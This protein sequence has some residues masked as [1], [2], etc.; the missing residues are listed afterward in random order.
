MQASPKSQ[1]INSILFYDKMKFSGFISLWAILSSFFNYKK[2][3]TT[4][5]KK[6]KICP[7]W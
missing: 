7:Y 2:L 6:N 1:I 5:R 3:E 4:Y